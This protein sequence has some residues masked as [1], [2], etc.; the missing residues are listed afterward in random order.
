MPQYIKTVS[1]VYGS[2]PGD[3]DP[4]DVNQGM[5]GEYTWIVPEYTSKR[6]EAASG[7]QVEITKVKDLH[8]PDLSKGDGREYFRYLHAF[9]TFG[10]IAAI[11]RVWLSTTKGTN[12]GHGRT[13]DINKGRGG[14]FLYLCWEYESQRDIAYSQSSIGK[15]IGGAWEDE[16]VHQTIAAMENSS[17][18]DRRAYIAARF[19]Q[20]RVVPIRRHTDAAGDVTRNLMVS[21]DNRR[22]YIMRA[23]LPAGETIPVRIATSRERRLELDKK[24][25]SKNDGFDIKVRGKSSKPP[26]DEL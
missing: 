25:T 18:E 6:S 14:N 16:T 23:L 4:H 24:W 8:A 2:R 20:L 10:G 3:A 19:D 11:T 22:L 26:R 13:E 15:L 9:Y 1:V 17:I 21:L 7:F 12:E 5:G